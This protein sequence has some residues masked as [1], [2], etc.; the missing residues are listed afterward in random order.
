MLYNRPIRL[1]V[2][3]NFDIEGIIEDDTPDFK[4]SIDFFY[5]I[6]HFIL[7]KNSFIEDEKY[8]LDG[9]HFISIS[10]TIFRKLNSYY[11]HHF[12]Y[13]LAKGV[14]IRTPYSVEKKK[15][16]S[17]RFQKEFFQKKLKYV[18][19]T[20]KTLEKKLR[21]QYQDEA[22]DKLKK[23]YGFLL[24]QL[25]FNKITIDFDRAFSD[26]NTGD[27][28][29][30]NYTAYLK[31]A[32]SMT[33]IFMGWKKCSYKDKTDARFHSPITRLN[34]NLRKYITFNNK[35]LAEVDLSNSVFYM[36]YILILNSFGNRASIGHRASTPSKPNVLL[37]LQEN[38]YTVD[39]DEL[40]EFGRLVLSGEFYQE[41][42]GDF[43]DRFVPT[44]FNNYYV[45]RD[46]LKEK[47]TGEIEQIKKI[48][49]RK[50]ISMIYAPNNSIPAVEEIFDWRFPTILKLIKLLKEGEEEDAHK[51]F[52]HLI[53]QYEA[54][55]MLNN[56]ARGYNNLNRRKGKLLLTLH[57]CLITTEDNVTDLQKYVLQYFIEAVGIAPK[58]KIKY[59]EEKE[60]L[61][62]ERPK[63]YPVL[64]ETRLSRP[65]KVYK[66]TCPPPARSVMKT[67]LEFA[68]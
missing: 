3:Y 19:I 67:E 53:F 46:I 58:T 8:W 38:S 23:K 64:R 12:D 22:P 39:R 34:S 16:F 17:Y 32:F 65:R 33:H 68:S 21:K 61:A 42:M 20:D 15:N 1:L 41:L 63:S 24:T 49:K 37:I 60:T 25:N 57:D 52:S 40:A 14:F 56:I 44:Y 18:D 66:I 47:F 2:P 29:T 28:P 51:P 59:W 36:L 6:V 4:Y 26:L 45:E 54:N 55:H 9:N 30:V 62:D 13:L 11:N 43:I 27:L 5:Y 35:K 48:V 10:S 7:Q 50:I 31:S